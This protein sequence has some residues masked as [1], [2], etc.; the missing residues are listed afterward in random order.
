MDKKVYKKTR[1]REYFQYLVKWKGQPITEA[2]WVT[3]EI[4]HKL[5]KSVEELMD[6]SP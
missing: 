4:L 2:T 5:G 3:E 1:A 6:T